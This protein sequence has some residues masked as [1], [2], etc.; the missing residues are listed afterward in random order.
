MLLGIK[1]I[2]EKASI[3]DGRRI[4]VDG[5]WPRGV[6]KSTSNIDFW[7]KDIAP[8]EDLRRWFNNDPKKWVSFKKKYEAEIKKNPAF[9]ALQEKVRIEDVTLVY[10]ASDGKRN[11]AAAIASFLKSHA[12][13][14]KKEDIA[15]KVAEDLEKELQ[16]Q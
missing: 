13:K 11:N 4:L 14:P 16:M 12:P 15:K 8:S 2:Y 9:K 7:M 3:T 5:L 6:R 10:A 1:R